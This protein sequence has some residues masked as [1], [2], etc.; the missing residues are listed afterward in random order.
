MFF[1]VFEQ[2]LKRVNETSESIVELRQIL[3][4]GLAKFIWQFLENRCSTIKIK[5]LFSPFTECLLCIP[6]NFQLGGKLGENLFTSATVNHMFRV[7][8]LAT[9]YLN[10]LSNSIPFLLSLS[11]LLTSFRAISSNVPLST[12]LFRR[13]RFER[14]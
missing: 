12:P 10:S 7:P 8:I 4:V 14:Q 5:K 11:C 13:N 1:H 2:T 6:F 3:R 9:S